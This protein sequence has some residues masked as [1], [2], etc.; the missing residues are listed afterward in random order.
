VIAI[1][2]TSA[3]TCLQASIMRVPLGNLCHVPLICTFT[4][5]IRGAW[6]RKQQGRGVLIEGLGECADQRDV[7]QVPQRHAHDR[8][9]QAGRSAGAALLLSPKLTSPAIVAMCLVE[10]GMPPR[11]APG[12]EPAKD[13]HGMPVIGWMPRPVIAC[14][15]TVA[16]G[17]GI[18]TE[19]KLSEECRQGVMELFAH[20]SSSRLPHLRPGGECRLQ[21]FSVE[22]GN[23]QSHFR[24]GKVKKPKN[25]D[26]GRASVWMTSA[27]SCARAASA[28]RRRSRDDPVLGSRTAAAT[29]RCPCIPAS[30]WRTNYSLNTV[31]ICPVARSPAMTSASRCASGP[32]GHQEHLHQ[33]RPRL[34][35]GDRLAREVVHRQTPR[36]NNDVNST[37]MWRPGPARFHFVN[38]DYRLT[39][40]LIK[41]DGKHMAAS[42]KQPSQ[43]SPRHS[44]P[45]LPRGRHH[46]LRTY[47]Q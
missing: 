27:A 41:K 9:L 32:Q 21:E 18:R 12:T 42:W 45:H 15:N 3:P 35:H 19:G 20:Q 33:V 23:G 37:W 40:P 31:D 28:S 47:D 43:R 1:G 34:Q 36:E 8:G 25:V 22:H 39:Q 44:R 14:A 30:A 10:M 46:R 17:Q 7:A 5:S 11:P 4:K 38:S 26:I 13:E 6:T 16:E 24:E 29:P 2:G